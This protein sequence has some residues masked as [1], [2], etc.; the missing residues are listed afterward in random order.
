MLVPQINE[1]LLKSEHRRFTNALD[2]WAAK[3]VSVAERHVHEHV[4]QESTFRRWKVRS[5][6]DSGLA[7]HQGTWRSH[8][9]TVQAYVNSPRYALPIE[10][11]AKAHW[12]FPRQAGG[13]LYFF[14]EKLGRY[15]SLP[16]VWHPGNKPYWFLRNATRSAFGVFGQQMQSSMTSAARSF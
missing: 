13:R 8:E 5:L 15:V 6:K 9:L 10:H 2:Y 12:I 16:Y 3:A 1:Q 11:G 7:R 4:Q 14:W